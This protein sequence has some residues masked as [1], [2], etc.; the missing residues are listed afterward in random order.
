MDADPANLC[1]SQNK[2]EYNSRKSGQ[3]CDE[4]GVSKQ[5]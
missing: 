2:T 1:K 4:T 3:K 5:V